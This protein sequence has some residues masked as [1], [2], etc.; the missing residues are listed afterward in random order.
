MLSPAVGKLLSFG[1]GETYLFSRAYRREQFSAFSPHHLHLHFIYFSVT[2]PIK[3]NKVLKRMVPVLVVPLCCILRGNAV[4]SSLALCNGSFVQ[5][6]HEEQN[7]AL[8]IPVFKNSRTK[9]SH[10]T[11]T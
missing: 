1:E 11:L 2:L 8:N 10:T 7:L 5:T 9:I 6:L 4:G 3:L